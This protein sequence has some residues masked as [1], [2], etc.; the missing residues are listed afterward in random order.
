MQVSVETISELERKMS[1]QLPEQTIKDKVEAR[2]KNIA[3]DI[4]LD[5]FRPG[6]IPPTIIRKRFGS[7]VR[8]EVLGDLMKSS[9]QDAITEQ[10]LQLA[11]RP[12]ITPETIDDGE[13]FKYIAS[14]EVLPEISL[15]DL[16][17]LKVNCATA[18]LVEDDVDAAIDRLRRQ[19]TVW[20]I[21][22][23][24]AKDGDRVT[25][26]FS[27][28]AAGE[29]FTQGGVRNQPVILGSKTMIVGFEE[30]LVG[31]EA[32]QLLNFEL[33]FPENYN[34][35]HLAGKTASFEV[36]V[37]TVEEGE[38]PEVDGDFVKGFG[39]KNGDI[40][41]FREDIRKNLQREM[42][43]SI[44]AK[45]KTVIVDALLETHDINLPKALIDGEATR[46]KESAKQDAQRTINKID[47]QN[48]DQRIQDQAIRR[49]KLGLIFGELVKK[50]DIKP[51]ESLVRSK[52]ESMAQ[53][54][55]DP[56][57][58]VNWYYSNPD[59]LK[60]IEQLVFEEQIVDWVVE[61]AEVT[62]Q[63]MSFA[64]LMDVEPIG[65]LQG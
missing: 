8:E 57:V 54:Y 44:R 30:K 26:H 62:D 11:G 45:L 52:I 51:D 33:D 22:E 18:E 34:A 63:T 53:S 9:F 32:G 23:R 42:D 15:A 37:V 41:A 6:K 64:E 19:K 12:L 14:F 46:L 16:K 49:V 65:S 61:Q 25:I 47:E 2:L 48:S 36:E 20:K 28:K 21:V 13:G 1:V 4:R 40:D 38:L 10:N 3:K 43:E 39:A 31:T 56:E 50:L 5:G 27:G 55:E 58:V 60:H 29:D 17:Q 7:R 35:E 24:P 59:Q